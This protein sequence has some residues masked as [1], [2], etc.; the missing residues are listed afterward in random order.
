MYM[1]GTIA[2][3]ATPDGTI[4]VALK[5][6]RSFAFAEG[7]G[8]FDTKTLDVKPDETVTLGLP[9]EDYY[10]DGPG[11]DLIT[12]PR[13]GVVITGDRRVRVELGRYLEDTKT[14]IALTIHLERVPCI[15]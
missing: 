8:A 3:R 9:S 11:A 4:Q 12:N 2:G 1:D 7:G 5:T 6:K 13:P 10:V 15:I 14:S